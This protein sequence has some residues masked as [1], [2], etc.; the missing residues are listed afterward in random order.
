M[1]MERVLQAAGPCLAGKTV[2]RIIVGISMIG[3]QLSDGAVGISY[4]LRDGLPNGC[5]VF[6]LVQEVEG[7]PADEIAKWVVS[8]EDDVLRGIGAAVLNAAS[9]DL[10]IPDDD[11]P[12]PFGLKIKKDDIV[13]MVGYIRPVAMQLRELAAE[14]RIF[15]Q[16]LYRAGGDEAICPT[17]Q[18][19]QLL[20]Q[21]DVVIL[22]G[23][24]T[25]NQTL[26]GLLVMCPKA[27]EIVLVGT[28]TPMFPQGFVGTGVTRLAGA[29]WN[30]ECVDEI[31]KVISLAGGVRQ[32]SA[33]KTMKNVLVGADL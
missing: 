32:L 13:G 17:E 22:S 8:R 15:D 33:Y 9:H 14:M 11:S 3:C 24:T 29:W 5:S 31:F 16:G 25:I 6:P 1:I 12:D 21:C 26:D 23:T 30:G 7:S 4:T 10:D 19:G 20:P 18:E 28:S 27:R 2:S